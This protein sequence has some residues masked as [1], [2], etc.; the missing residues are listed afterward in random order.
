MKKTI[1][2]V[3]KHAQKQVVSRRKVIP[4]A[5]LNFSQSKEALKLTAD[6][7][8][9]FCSKRKRFS[10]KLLKMLLLGMT[11]QGI[12]KALFCGSEGATQA[13]VQI[14]VNTLIFSYSKISSFHPGSILF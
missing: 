6:W 11:D 2:E 12:V 4:E 1:D 3:K 8:F 7:L 14:L 9:S 5:S 13:R 10:H